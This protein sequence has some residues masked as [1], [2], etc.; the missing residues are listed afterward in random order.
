MWIVCYDTGKR[1]ITLVNQVFRE[2]H[3]LNKS[4]KASYSS[5]II[6]LTCCETCWLFYNLLWTSVVD[7]LLAFNL[8]L[9]CRTACCTASCTTNPQ[10]IEASGVRHN[11]TYQQFSLTVVAC[12]LPLFWAPT[13]AIY[14][15]QVV[16]TWRGD[17]LQTGKPSRC[18]TNTQVNS[19]F[20]PSGVGKPSTGLQ[21]RGYGGARSPVSGGR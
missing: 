11:Q 17:C 1:N 6:N 13:S 5:K 9:I 10:H 3:S 16:S 20:H 19:A 15:V 12:S 14:I 18:I 7:L 21:G 4:R 8:L 2:V